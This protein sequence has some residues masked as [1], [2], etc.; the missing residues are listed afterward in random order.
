MT[1]YRLYRGKLREHPE[2]EYVR[3]SDI[4]GTGPLTLFRWLPGGARGG[5]MPA[6][7]TRLLCLG[8]DR[9]GRLEPVIATSTGDLFPW[10]LV[11]WYV[12]IEELM[13][14]E[15]TPRCLTSEFGVGEDC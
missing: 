13:P 1:S 7:G 5:E 14:K 10:H 9:S 15:P 4:P 11:E 3:P 12:P 6:E 8:L 2:G